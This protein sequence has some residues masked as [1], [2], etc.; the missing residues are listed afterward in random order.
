M[1]KDG[2]AQCLESR[3]RGTLGKGIIQR[4]SYSI[5]GYQEEHLEHSPRQQVYLKSVTMYY[6]SIK[7]SLC[8]CSVSSSL[9]LMRVR[10][11]IA[12]ICLFAVVHDHHE[13][14]LRGGSVMLSFQSSLKEPLIPLLE[15]DGLRTFLLIAFHHTDSNGIGTVLRQV[16][17]EFGVYTY[18]E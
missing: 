3:R 14:F 12:M 17:H 1:A 7:P 16:M 4:V 8:K 2:S 5:I 10:A 15:S 11:G 18:T 9:F 13:N 6:N